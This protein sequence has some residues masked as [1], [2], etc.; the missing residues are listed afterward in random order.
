M[1]FAYSSVIV[2]LATEKQKTLETSLKKIPLQIFPSQTFIS[3]KLCLAILARFLTTGK[4][5]G[6]MTFDLGLLK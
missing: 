6:D 5:Q 4:L 1:F 3:G 2:T